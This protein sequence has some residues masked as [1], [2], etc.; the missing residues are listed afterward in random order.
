MWQTKFSYVRSWKYPSYSVLTEQWSHNSFSRHWA[1]NADSGECRG[2]SCSAR[3]F[4][5]LSV[6][7]IWLL[8][9]PLKWN[10]VKFV[11]TTFLKHEDL[12]VK[13]KSRCQLQNFRATGSQ[14]QKQVSE[15]VLKETAHVWCFHWTGNVAAY[16]HL[17]VFIDACSLCCVW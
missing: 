12:L 15:S 4:S 16:L 9:Y 13:K 7:L 14:K 2:F 3:R 6:L 5:A 10:R 11:K 17:S 8:I 1:P